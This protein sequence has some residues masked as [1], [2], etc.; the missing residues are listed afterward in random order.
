MVFHVKEMR[1]SKKDD[2]IHC[3]FSLVNFPILLQSSEVFLLVLSWD[4]IRVGIKG[5]LYLRIWSSARLGS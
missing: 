2:A 5:Y 3:I 1:E 4:N